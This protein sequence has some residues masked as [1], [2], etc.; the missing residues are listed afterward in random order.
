MPP[1][2]GEADTCSSSSSLRCAM[3]KKK[4]RST[5]VV[6]PILLTAWHRVS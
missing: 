6:G 5:Y 2:P 4:E 1:D 3:V